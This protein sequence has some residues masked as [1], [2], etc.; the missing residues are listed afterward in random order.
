[1]VACGGIELLILPGF[2]CPPLPCCCP[3]SEPK[4]LGFVAFLSTHDTRINRIFLRLVNGFVIAAAQRHISRWELNKCSLRS[5]AGDAATDLRVM[6]H[7]LGL[8][9]TSLNGTSKVTNY[10]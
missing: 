6:R 9:S 7:S 8:V 10:L 1:M 2:L 4:K 5:C 3:A